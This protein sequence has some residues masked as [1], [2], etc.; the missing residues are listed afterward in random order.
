MVLGFEFFGV[1]GYRGFGVWGP[2]VLALGFRLR[3]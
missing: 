3:L 1:W 2:W